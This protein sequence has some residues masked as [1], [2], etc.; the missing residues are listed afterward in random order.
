MRGRRVS[1]MHFT[2]LAHQITCSAKCNEEEARPLLTASLMVLPL[3]PLS[4]IH[5]QEISRSKGWSF[6]F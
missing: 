2:F 6:C 4:L 3:K 5:C 1:A